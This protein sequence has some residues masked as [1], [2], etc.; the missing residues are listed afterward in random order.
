MGR[1]L[2]QCFQ[3]GIKSR[4]GE[5]V[6]FVNYVNLV[7]SRGGQVTYHGPGQVVGYPIL[8]LSS[9]QGPRWYVGG[10]EEMIM[11]TLA[12][13]DIRGGREAGLPGVWAEDGKTPLI[14]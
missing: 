5:H 3:Q 12:E 2:F 13:F 6:H 8:G 11:R 1:R 4:D 9:T 14:F 7:S 10:L